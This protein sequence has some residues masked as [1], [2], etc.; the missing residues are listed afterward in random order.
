MGIMPTLYIKDDVV[1]GVGPKLVM[2]KNFS[3]SKF[4]LSA[5]E[6]FYDD[7]ESERNIELFSTFKLSK[8]F[9][10]NIKYDID[11]IEDIKDEHLSASLFYYF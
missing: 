6:N 1:S 8:S 4:G 11:K 7:G 5:S 10:L 2:L 3:T 9:A